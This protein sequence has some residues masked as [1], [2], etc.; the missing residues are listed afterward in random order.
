M[1][2]WIM[3]LGFKGMIYPWIGSHFQVW[4]LNKGQF[5]FVSSVLRVTPRA[6]HSYPKFMG[7]HPY[8]HPGFLPSTFHSSFIALIPSFYLSPPLSYFSFSFFFSFSYFSS[9]FSYFFSSSSF[10]SLLCTPS[11]SSHSS[12]S[13]IYFFPLFSMYTM[14]FIA[15]L[16]V[17]N[18]I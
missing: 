10:S 9:F 16:V 17:W 13:S 4:N 14:Q 2:I 6:A 1:R 3:M 8:S 18:T 5:S 12:L 11:P 7:V 15:Y